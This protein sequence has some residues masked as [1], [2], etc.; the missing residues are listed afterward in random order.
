MDKLYIAFYKAWNKYGDITDR[1]IAVWTKGPYSHT[2][3]IIPNPDSPTG[4]TM[5]SALGSENKVRCKEHFINYEIFDYYPIYV[6]DKEI[7]I[8]FFN[9]IK[10]A[11]YDYLGII[12]SQIIPLGMDSN[13]KWFCSESC[14]KATQLSGI[15]NKSIWLAKPEYIHPNKLAQF[16]GLLEYPN[17]KHNLF[18]LLPLLFDKKVRTEKEE[19]EKL[20]NCKINPTT[21]DL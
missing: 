18:K 11:E 5:C 20:F 12:M 15:D 9:T 8:E 2:E 17:G 4:L 1:T 19:Y 16:V 6:R 7:A 21:V 13:K 10:N 14:T 3:L